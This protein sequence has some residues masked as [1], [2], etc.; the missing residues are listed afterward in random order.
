MEYLDRGFLAE[1]DRN[2]K[3]WEISMGRSTEQ[4][5]EIN[6]PITV[7]AVE[8]SVAHFGKDGQ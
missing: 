7:L 3:Y 5:K 1:F 2:P 6:Y 8:W 4:A